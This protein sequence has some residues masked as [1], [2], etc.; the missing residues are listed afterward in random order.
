SETQPTAL[1]VVYDPKGRLSTTSGSQAITAAFDR[2]Q[3]LPEVSGVTPPFDI[4]KYLPATISH[5]DKLAVGK[6]NYGVGYR[7]LGEATLADLTRAT[8]PLRALGMRMYYGG[9]VVD[10][11]AA[12]SGLA[13]YADELGLIV[14]ALLLIL[15]FRSVV[16]ALLP[17]V[18]AL[19][20]LAAGILALHLLANFFAI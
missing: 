9:P 11:L 6:V 18:N 20:G 7:D 19:A 5:S 13:K 12:E 4:G 16:S 2:I 15:L 1:I 17:L 10:Y 14:A 3:R 8:S